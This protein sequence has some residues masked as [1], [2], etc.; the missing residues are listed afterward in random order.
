MNISRLVCI[1]S[2][3]LVLGACKE[4]TEAD[5]EAGTEDTGET[6]DDS[7]N[8][9]GACG[10]ETETILEDIFVT[11]EGFATPINELLAPLEGNFEGNFAWHEADGP[12]SAAH[13][14]NEAM[15]TA[16]LAYSGGTV[17]LVE[18]ENAGEPPD[19]EGGPSVCSNYVVVDVILEFT[20]ADGVFAESLVVPLTLNALEDGLSPTF[21]QSL[22][23][24]AMMGTLSMDDFV[25][26]DGTLSDAVLY[27]VVSEAALAGEFGIEIMSG[28]GPDGI[29]SFGI[30]A[31]YD[32]PRL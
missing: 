3:A 18:V 12:W 5:S 25:T 27:G 14:G 7:E 17:R 28:A 6:G 9:A 15:L 21:Y 2:F 22:D 13:A 29:V 20:T 31:E 32:A 16:A 4:G 11:P 24:D 23:L 30:I 10:E 8:T 1:T 19:G 26:G